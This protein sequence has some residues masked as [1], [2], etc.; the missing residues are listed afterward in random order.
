MKNQA[1]LVKG[2]DFDF[3][4]AS[5]LTIYEIAQSFGGDAYYDSPAQRVTYMLENICVVPMNKLSKVHEELNE[6]GRSIEELYGCRYLGNELYL[7][8]SEEEAKRLAEL[9]TDF[10]FRHV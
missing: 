7:S 3:Q 2:V 10:Y 5:P 4:D 8:T 6:I 1:V 9:G